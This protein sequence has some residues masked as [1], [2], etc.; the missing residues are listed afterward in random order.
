MKFKKVFS[1]ASLPKK[2]RGTP[3]I[4]FF[5]GE[6]VRVLPNRSAYIPFG[7][8]VED[9]PDNAILQLSLHDS[10]VS[11][12]RPFII[13]NGVQYVINEKRPDSFPIGIHVYNRSPNV[14]AT[15][16]LGEIVAY[17]VLIPA[18]TTTTEK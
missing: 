17:G 15:V 4:V 1:E 7:V 16:E 3:L 10:L 11:G 2:V 13:P 9:I 6:T 12:I 18:Y 8:S 14:P 5:A